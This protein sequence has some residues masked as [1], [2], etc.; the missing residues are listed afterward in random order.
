MQ[1]YFRSPVMSTDGIAEMSNFSSVI[2]FPNFFA[3]STNIE[4]F[5]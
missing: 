4:L 2:A 3:G 1:K 5:V